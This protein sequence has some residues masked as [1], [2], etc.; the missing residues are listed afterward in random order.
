MGIGQVGLAFIAVAEAR[1]AELPS[2]FGHLN[3]NSKS[4]LAALIFRRISDS[5]F[6]GEPMIQMIKVLD[7]GWTV[8]FSK[9]LLRYEPSLIHKW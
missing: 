1:P 8:M 6:L 5:S 2:D 9:A 7:Y 4:S 3:S